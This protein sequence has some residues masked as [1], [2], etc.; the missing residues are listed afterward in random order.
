M[1]S[2]L[3]LCIYPRGEVNVF[4]TAQRQ[5]AQTAAAQW[6]QVCSVLSPQTAVSFDPLP[7]ARQLPTSHL[8]SDPIRRTLHGQPR[9]I[10]HV[11]IDHRRP[12]IFVPQ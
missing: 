7:L 3:Q 11:Q 2:M 4:K 8:P 1:V 5:P 6:P 12:D 10:H 9:F